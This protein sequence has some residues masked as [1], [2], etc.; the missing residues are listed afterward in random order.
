V[1]SETGQGSGDAD[2]ALRILK[3]AG[4]EFDGQTLTKNGEPVGPFRLRSTAT[5]LRATTMELVQSYLAAIG[6][7]V[8]IETTDDLGGML[9]NADYDIA[10]FGWSGSPF[11][12]S[13]PAQQWHSD[14][15]SNFGKYANEEVDDLLDASRR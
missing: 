11:F 3:E 15:G 9:G 5:T 14:S 12:T 1:V 10:Q 2:A 6:I 13:L 7:E 4:Y 8:T